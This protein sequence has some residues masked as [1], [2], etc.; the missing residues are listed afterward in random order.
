MTIELFIIILYSLTVKRYSLLIIRHLLFII[1]SHSIC[2]ILIFIDEYLSFTA[3]FAFCT[4][5]VMYLLSFFFTSPQ[6]GFLVVTAIN[7]FFGIIYNYKSDSILNKIDVVGVMIVFLLEVIGV[8]HVKYDP[9]LEQ[10]YD[11][12]RIY[13]HYAYV[14]G[15]L[16][17]YN[18]NTVLTA[19]SSHEIHDDFH[20]MNKCTGHMCCSTY[21]SFYKSKKANQFNII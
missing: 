2:A 6:L 17:L 12:C 3:I 18:A 19:C 15:L 7:I 13:P 10:L 21:Y 8:P 20:P 11:F 4:L 14:S 9:L 16:T 1:R 5:P